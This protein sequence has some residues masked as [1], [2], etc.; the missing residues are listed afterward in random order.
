MNTISKI[1]V[2]AAA[3]VLALAAGCHNDKPQQVR[4][5]AFVPEDQPR[6]LRNVILGQEANGARRDATLHPV[7]FDDAGLNS[8][9]QQKLNLMLA[10]DEPAEPLVVY[11]DFPEG[12]MPPHAHD[13]VVDYL[14]HCGLP[15]AQV[16]LKDGPNPH[17]ASS[18]AEATAAIHALQAAPAG[19]GAGSPAPAA[20]AAGAVTS[21]PT[22]TTGR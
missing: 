15:E 5:D 19:A 7:H 4:R 20:G 11:L 12:E 17:A 1:S 22:S 14:K 9:G 21:G 18:A 16:S 6:Q 2:M 10:S 8:L 3:A 13:S